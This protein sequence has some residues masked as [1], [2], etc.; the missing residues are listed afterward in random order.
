MK[1]KALK[2]LVLTI[3]LFVT[4]FTLSAKT[5]SY[6]FKGK[7]ANTDVRVVLNIN[8]DNYQVNGSYY[9]YNAQGKKQSQE[10]KLNG[11]CNPVDPTHNYFFISESFD[12]NYCGGWETNFNTRTK[13]MVGTITNSK[14]KK[15]DID[16]QKVE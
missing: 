8:T 4:P 13:R 16:L 3:V 11:H 9:Y 5:V 12:G 6:L 14:G 7:I 2:F 15:Y 1:T 10:I